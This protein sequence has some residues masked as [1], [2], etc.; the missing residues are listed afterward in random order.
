MAAKP[1][2]GKS[3]TKCQ[4]LARIGAAKPLQSDLPNRQLDPKRGARA[5]RT[6]Y[7]NRSVV[8]IDDLPDDRKTEASAAFLGGEERLEKTGLGFPVHAGSEVSDRDSHQAGA[9]ASAPGEH[10]A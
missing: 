2:R 8:E 6:L 4:R 10:P 5:A 3:V 9:T 1:M 7:L